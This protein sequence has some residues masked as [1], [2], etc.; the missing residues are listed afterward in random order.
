M[1]VLE[2]DSGRLTTVNLEASDLGMSLYPATFDAAIDG[3]D[4]ALEEREY[5]TDLL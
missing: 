4:L 1:L 3:N 2:V 5:R